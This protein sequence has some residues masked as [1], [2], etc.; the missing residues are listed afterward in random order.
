MENLW[1]EKGEEGNAES[2]DIDLTLEDLDELEKAITEKVLP[3]TTGFFFG[4]DSYNE[5]GKLDLDYDLDFIV[6]ARKR[7]N[8]GETVCYSCWW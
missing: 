2:L 4:I 1:R 6:K 3:E 7:V 8:N 5:Y